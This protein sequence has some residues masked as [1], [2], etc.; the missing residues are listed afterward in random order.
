MCQIQCQIYFNTD[1]RATSILHDSKDAA[2]MNYLRGLIWYSNALPL[3]I[4]VLS[5]LSPLTGFHSDEMT[6]MANT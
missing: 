5:I 2:V 6:A 4:R 1:Y 3:S